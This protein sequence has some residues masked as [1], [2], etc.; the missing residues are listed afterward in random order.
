MYIS[1]KGS[2]IFR[3]PFLFAFSMSFGF[4]ALHYLTCRTRL[5]SNHSFAF[6]KTFSTISEPSIDN[7]P[8]KIRSGRLS[9]L[10]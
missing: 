4:A 9:R 2:R 10:F 8:N 1:S 6:I 5:P 7:A 3:E